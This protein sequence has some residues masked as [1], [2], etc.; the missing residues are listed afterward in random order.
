[1]FITTKQRLS[2]YLTLCGII[3]GA[4]MMQAIQASTPQVPSAEEALQFVEDLIKKGMDVANN[5]N[6]S[7]KDFGELLEKN[8]VTK[9]IANFVLGTHGRGMTPEQKER[10]HQ[11]YKKRLVQ[12]YSTP[13]KIKTFKNTTHIINPKTTPESDGS[14]LV[15][16]TFTNQS[17]PNAQPA[18]VD[19][20]IVKKDQKLFIFDILFEGISKLLTE[21]Q[22]YNAIYTA[23]DKGNNQAEKFLS[24]L[25]KEVNG[26][27]TH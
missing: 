8:F 6:A 7:E 1:M 5:P 4:V 9:E 24:Y 2:V 27:K 3:L 25:D 19:W 12:I 18:K 26:S 10:F 20:K 15:K 21:R 13:E 17:T 14:L 16:S 11:L 22:D 23:S